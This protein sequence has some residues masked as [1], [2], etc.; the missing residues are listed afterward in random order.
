MAVQTPIPV[1]FEDVFPHGAFAMDVS[2]MD[3]FDKPQDTDRQQRDKVTGLRM[4]QVRVLD[5]DPAARKGQTEL[6]VKIAA[7]V[8]PVPP[9]AIPGTPFR[10]VVFDDLSITPYVDER[11]SRPRVAYS[12]RASGM[13]SAKSAAPVS[14]AKQAA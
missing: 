7:E 4:W 14:S 13:R 9:E 5:G 10:P 12:L 1:G 2:S 3:D 8:Q 11:R 6:T